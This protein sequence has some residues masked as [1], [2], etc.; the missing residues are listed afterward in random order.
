MSLQFEAHTARLAAGRNWVAAQAQNGKAV[1]E[2]GGLSDT[3]RANEYYQMSGQRSSPLVVGP[4][5]HEAFYHGFN[6]PDPWLVPEL[7]IYIAAVLKDLKRSASVT[8]GRFHLADASQSGRFPVD[9]T[10][11]PEGT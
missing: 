2:Q 7:R 1:A 5:S 10:H 8:L 3:T 11:F 6:L 4:Q 9:V